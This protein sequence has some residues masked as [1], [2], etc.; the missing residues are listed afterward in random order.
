MQSEIASMRK[1][2]EEQWTLINNAIH[3][4][5]HLC[6]QQAEVMEANRDYH[7]ESIRREAM[8]TK[9]FDMTHPDQYCGGTQQLDHLTWHVTI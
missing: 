7:S 9:S 3:Q 5:I 2:M 1:M 8:K 6:V 4:N